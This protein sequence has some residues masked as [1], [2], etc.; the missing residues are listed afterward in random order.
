MVSILSLIPYHVTIHN[1]IEYQKPGHLS[2]F[3]EESNSGTNLNAT[4]FPIENYDHIRITVQTRIRIQ[5][6]K[7][8]VKSISDFDSESNAIH[9]NNEY[10]NAWH[11]SQFRVESNSATSLNATPFPI[12]I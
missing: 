8:C 7:K 2:R 10:Q 1:N 9:N 6:L 12:E 11:L 5:T 4:S 3:W